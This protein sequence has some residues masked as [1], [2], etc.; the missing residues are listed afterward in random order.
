MYFQN[1]LAKPHSQ[2]STI[3]IGNQNNNIQFGIMIFCREVFYKMQ[4]FSC[5]HREQHISKRHFEIT[6]IISWSLEFNILGF[7]IEVWLILLGSCNPN[8]N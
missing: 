6:V 2:I 7:G 5:K 8:H 4:L 1:D 3:N